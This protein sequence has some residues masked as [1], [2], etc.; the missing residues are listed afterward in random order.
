MTMV[1][2]RRLLGE[3]VLLLSRSHYTFSSINKHYFHII[4]MNAL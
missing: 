3:M 4:L 2:S 1:T